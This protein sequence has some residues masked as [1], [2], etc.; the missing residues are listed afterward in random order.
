MNHGNLENA[1]IVV[2]DHLSLG[3]DLL[4]P[5]AEVVLL[6][7]IDTNE[8]G[9]LD[10]PWCEYSDSTLLLPQMSDLLLLLLRLLSGGLGSAVLL[11]LLG[12]RDLEILHLAVG[13]GSFGHGGGCG[14]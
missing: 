12:L 7:D 5:L 4:V 2:G 3:D 6:C 1:Y 13:G 10:L 8:R 14:M 11:A 9:A